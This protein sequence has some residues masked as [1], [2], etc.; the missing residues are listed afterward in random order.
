MES[1]TG[2]QKKIVELD[3]FGV[4]VIPDTEGNLHPVWSAGE[5]PPQHSR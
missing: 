3:P 2:I 1:T 5:E 4:E